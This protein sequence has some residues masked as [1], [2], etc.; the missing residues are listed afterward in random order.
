[1]TFAPALTRC[2]LACVIGVL[3]WS[4]TERLSSLLCLLLLPLVVFKSATRSSAFLVAFCYYAVGAHAVP[5]IITGFFPHVSMGVGL[6]I[7]G[8]DAALLA[9]PWALAFA[10]AKAAGRTLGA[11]NPTDWTAA[12]GLTFDGRRLAVPRMAM[13]R[14]GHHRC[15]AGF[16]RGRDALHAPRACRNRIGGRGTNTAT[17]TARSWC[18]RGVQLAAIGGVYIAIREAR[19]TCC[20]G[21]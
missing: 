19:R 3:A 1:M 14:F 4:D 13:G 10:G 9:L 2:L 5:G 7:W 12:L 17:S 21:A 18:V 15:F 8:A 16:D 11:L 6:L 20:N